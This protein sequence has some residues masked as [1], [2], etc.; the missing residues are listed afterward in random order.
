MSF[1]VSRDRG[2]YEWAGTSLSA[3]FAQRRNLVNPAQWRMVFDILRF[4]AAA[5]PF[6]RQGD[7]KESIGAY[8]R[9]QG[10]SDAFR[11]NYLLP[12]TAAI[13][14]TP[15]DQAALDFPALTLLRF[16]HNHHL[17][18][19][20]DRPAWLTIARGSHGYVNAILAKLPKQQLHL[21]AGIESVR[22][23]GGKVVLV[24]QGGEEETFDKVIFACHADTALAILEH[25]GGV[26]R[27]ER[28]VLGGFTFGENRA[29][30]HADVEVRIAFV[31]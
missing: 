8:L 11:D 24:R 17:L 27:E 22:N 10:Y 28:E 4:N 7:S 25:G 31:R 21:R 9:R 3:L 15:P 29:V 6:L 2:L 23:E 14:S 20:L 16:M 30:L 18:Q 19:L 1:A 13:W 12:M 5:V 26:T